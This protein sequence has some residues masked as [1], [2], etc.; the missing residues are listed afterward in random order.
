MKSS[1]KDHISQA[2]AQR[3]WAI[4]GVSR[5]RNKFGN[6]IYRDLRA[7]GY[8][9]SAVNPYATEVEGDPVWPTLLDLPERPDVV[10]VVVP[11]HVGRKIAD[12]A[13]KAGVPFFWLQPG[14]ESDDLINYAESL[15]LIVIHHACAMVEKKRWM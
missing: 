10:D 14:A 3:N 11:S 8:L 13:A 7:A 12:D 9:V 5:D 2:I 4:A 15:G 6:I 1:M